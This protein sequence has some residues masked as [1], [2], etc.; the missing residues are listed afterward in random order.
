VQSLCH[1]YYHVLAVKPMRF[2]LN[3]GSVVE[4]EKGTSFH[5]FHILSVVLAC[6]LIKCC[7]FRQNG[8]KKNSFRI[9]GS[10]PRMNHFLFQSN[11][12]SS[13]DYRSKCGTTR[14]FEKQRL[15]EATLHSSP[16]DC[17]KNR[18]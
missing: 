16:L 12:D 8:L 13:V 1:C 4:P 18:K 7:I 2:E 3:Y 9:R 17:I 15:Q 5:I 6:V 11:Y 14:F 10:N